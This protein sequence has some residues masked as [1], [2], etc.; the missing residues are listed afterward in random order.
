MPAFQGLRQVFH[1]TPRSTF[2]SNLRELLL[3]RIGRPW[4][5]GLI[6]SL[7]IGDLQKQLSLEDPR[8]LKG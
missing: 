7:F 5:G 4:I 1:I 8:D 2:H 6:I 3:V